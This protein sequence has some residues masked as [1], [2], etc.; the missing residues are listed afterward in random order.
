M[1]ALAAAAAGGRDIYVGGTSRMV[2]LWADLAK[3][4]GI[5]SLLDREAAVA[6][7]LDDQEEGTTVR[8]GPET[9]V[10]QDDLAV[11]STPYAVA[12]SKSRIGVVGPLRMDYRRTI[13]VVEEVSEALGETL[14]G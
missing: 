7:L 13:R 11:V 2:E 3:L 5:L 12:G 6:L 4:H 9:G 1:S 8:I 10:A 14:S